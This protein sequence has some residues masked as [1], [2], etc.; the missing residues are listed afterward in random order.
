M[1][2][3]LQRFLGRLR[4]LA[5]RVARHGGVLSGEAAAH[6][7]LAAATGSRCDDEPRYLAL[8]PRRIEIILPVGGVD[9]AGVEQDVREVGDVLR[10]RLDLFSTTVRL[11]G[12]PDVQALTREAVLAELLSDGGLALGLAGM[13]IRLAND[14]PADVDEVREI[15]KAARQGDRF[16]PL[17]ELLEVA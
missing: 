10:S 13:L 17:L 12:G 2:A 4:E 9:I 6:I 11:P 15:L 3:S 16:Q 1:T 7:H 14:P 8:G 5:P